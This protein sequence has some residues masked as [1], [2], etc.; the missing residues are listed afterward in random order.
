MS[1]RTRIEHTSTITSTSMGAEKARMVYSAHPIITH[2]GLECFQTRELHELLFFS[3]SFFFFS[4]QTK[5]CNQNRM[6][7]QKKTRHDFPSKKKKKK[8]GFS[9][10]P[11]IHPSIKKALQAPFRL[12]RRFC[13]P[14]NR[15][16]L[17]LSPSLENDVPLHLGR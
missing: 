17:S 10:H 12:G 11:S 5:R 8:I 16:S 1:V 9:M 15:S 6:N 4:F 7:A 3:F 2:S 14:R 13:S